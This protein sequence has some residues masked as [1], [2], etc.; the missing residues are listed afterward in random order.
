LASKGVY[1]EASEDDGARDPVDHIWPRGISKG[2]K[3]KGKKRVD[4]WFK[5]VAPTAVLRGWF[6]EG[7][8]FSDSSRE[9]RKELEERAES[10][11]AFDGLLELARRPGSPTLV[12]A[13]K[14][15]ERNNAV[16]PK[17][18]LEERIRLLPAP[19]IHLENALARGP[20][21]P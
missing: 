1:D 9:Y 11:K 15:P 19:G 3:P 5:L 2:K 16:V 13:G 18:A 12:H 21:Y 4:E 7:G 6:H 14:D 20:F 17:D 10:R 8:D